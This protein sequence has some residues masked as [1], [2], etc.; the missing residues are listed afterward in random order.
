MSIVVKKLNKSFA[1]KVVL[2]DVNMTFEKNKVTGL[3]GFNGSGKTT[4][5]N[6][7]VNFI[8]KYG[9][10]IFFDN[11]ELSKHKLK[12][13][14][15]DKQ[16]K[17]FKQISY[18]SAGANPKDG[19]RVR[20][21]LNDIAAIYKLNKE[22]KKKIIDNLAQQVEL[23][24]FIDRPIKTLSKGN[25][26]KLKI[27]ISLMNPHLKYLFL[28]EPFDGFDPIMTRKIQNMIMNL[29]DVTVIITSHQM[30]IVQNMCDNFYL[31]KD[32]IVVDSKKEDNNHILVV[33]N[34]EVED[35]Y[36]NKLSYFVKSEIK[37]NKKIITIENIDNF[38]NLNIEL[39]KCDKFVYCSLKEKNLAESVFEK[40][41]QN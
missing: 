1:E 40:Y 31:L 33:V 8:E 37:N 6:I 30:D 17:I 36:F 22:S 9:G 16:L 24:P 15:K 26:Q 27:V 32:G 38:K 34:P 35:E 21:F 4:T 18:L 5:F 2:K 7:L 10:K 11:V 29:K 12:A 13:H 19:T 41:E 20:T 23:T 28:D 39:L 25:Q 14:E 3:I